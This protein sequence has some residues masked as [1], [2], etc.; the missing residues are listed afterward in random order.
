MRDGSHWVIV[1]E[2]D[3]NGVLDPPDGVIHCWRRSPA[4]TTVGAVLAEPPV[5]LE[6]IR[7]AH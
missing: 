3:G 6:L 4:R 2:D 1:L 7:R 5:E